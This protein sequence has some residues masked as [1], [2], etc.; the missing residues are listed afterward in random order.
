MMSK[1]LRPWI[2]TALCAL[3]AI[4][5]VAQKSVDEPPSEAL[6]EDAADYATL[7]HVTLDEAVRRLRLQDEAG[8]LDAELREEEADEFAGLWI[9]HEPSFVVIARFVDPGEARPGL[10][11]RVKGTRLAGLVELRSAERSLTRLQDLLTVTRNRLDKAGARAELAV[12][13][14]TNRVKLFVVDPRGLQNA[15]AA[16]RL[17]LPEAVQV[18]QVAALSEPVTTVVGGTPASTCTWGFTVQRSNGEVGISTAAHC[19]NSQSYSGTNLPFRSEDQQGNQDVQW[20]SACDIFDVSD[21]FQSGIGLRSVSG[22]RSRSQQ[23]VGSLIWKHG[24]TTGRTHGE[25][26][27]KTFA[28]WWV[29]NAS[30]TFIYVDGDAVGIDGAEPGDSGSPVFVEDLAY[31]I[32]IGHNTTN[33]DSIYMAINYISSLG[34]S[35]LTSDPGSNCVVCGDGVCESGETCPADCDTSV[36]GD[37]VCD[38]GESCFAD[39]GS[40]C[41]PCIICPCNG[42]F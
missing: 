13:V 3:L 29:S 24:K 25:I 16:A 9:E 14:R 35:V 10:E 37:G 17:E 28:P 2:L 6:L 36:C 40:G 38:P 11:A 1:Y 31:G 27:Y 5:A 20:H 12:D 19:G 15:L 7:Y 22:T 26:D 42:Q 33:F 34:V 39:C 18:E 32:L 4:P 8:Q 30:S 23:A 21:E 41:E